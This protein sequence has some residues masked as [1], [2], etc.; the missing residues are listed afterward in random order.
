[1]HIQDSSL[2][3]ELPISIPYTVKHILVPLNGTACAEEALALAARLARAAGA[4]ITLLRI[5]PPTRRS[6]RY[7]LNIVH[8]E[9][10]PCQKDIE[11]AQTYLRCIAATVDLAGPGI[12]TEVITERSISAF[13]QYM[14]AHQVDLV[15]MCS[16]GYTGL[17]RWIHGSVAQQLFRQCPI[18]ILVL[19]EHSSSSHFIAESPAHPFSLLVPL[20]GTP[21]AE[22][23]LPVAAWL[24][25]ALSLPETGKLHL[26]RVIQPAYFVDD[27]ATAIVKK[28]NDDAVEQA[29][30]YLKQLQHAFRHGSFRNLHVNV[31]ASVALNTEPTYTIIRVAEEGETVHDQ[32]VSDG[33]DTIALAT[34]SRTGLPRWVAG[35]IAEQLLGKTSLPLLVIPHPY[36]STQAYPYIVITMDEP[37]KSGQG[38]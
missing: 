24:S 5:V 17:T 26:L 35:S 36:S 11:Q 25:S 7:P 13:I 27:Q 14:Q 28:L 21:M 20:D 8:V 37:G 3:Q 15:V 12:Q 34:H 4:R 22:T 16:H 9:A 31:T 19:R 1:M 10:E 23:A 33:Y 2:E 30:T 18:P 29:R 38:E 6:Q 32:R